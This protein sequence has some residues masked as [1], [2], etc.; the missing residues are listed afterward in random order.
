LTEAHYNKAVGKWLE[1]VQLLAHITGGQPSRGEEINGLHLVNGI[2]RDWNIFIIDGEVVLVTQ[3]HKSLAH[4]DS[5]KVIPQFLP[6]RVGQ[7]LVMYIIYIRPLT[8]R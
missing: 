6:A 3:C 5:P 4:F 8:D 2:T 1:L 7:L